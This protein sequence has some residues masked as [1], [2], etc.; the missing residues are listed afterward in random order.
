MLQCVSGQRLPALAKG[1]T[2]MYHH[3]FP[4]CSECSLHTWVTFS[5]L[6]SYVTLVHLLFFFH[7][8]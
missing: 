8:S 7:H 4:G 2:Q 3:F 6:A 5:C 1:M